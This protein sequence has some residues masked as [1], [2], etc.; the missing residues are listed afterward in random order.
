MKLLHVTNAYPPAPA[1]GG[2]ASAMRA[3]CQALSENT[4]ISINMTVAL[5]SSVQKEIDQAMRIAENDG[6]KLLLVDCWQIRRRGSTIGLIFPTLRG[7]KQLLRVV[8]SSDCVHIHGFRNSF[9]NFAGLLGVYFDKR[10]IVQPHGSAQIIG[11]SKIPKY[12]FDF[13][14]GRFLLRKSNY[15]L[16]LS[17]EEDTQIR[18]IDG[19]AEIV[20]I[21]NAVPPALAVGHN[22]TDSRSS[23][24]INLL[25]VGRL[26][27]KKGID[28]LVREIVGSDIGNRSLKLRIVGPD[29]GVE[30]EVRRLSNGDARIEF[31]GPLSGD[32]LVQEYRRADLLVVPSVTDT[33]PMVILEAAANRLPIAMTPSVEVSK[34]LEGLVAVLDPENLLPGIFSALEKPVLTRLKT[35]TREISMLYSL[36]SLS[37]KLCKIY[38]ISPTMCD[39]R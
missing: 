27:W 1:A 13:L 30:K 35:S 31:L 39:D 17:E 24:D 38:G 8:K 5:V 37:N 20:R 11:A 23:I 2:V 19:N 22:V 3:Q 32:S 36:G 29:D 6:V 14:F 18:E 21:W 16:S 12:V 25:F 9:S 33:F 7:L 15:V 26:N 34:S 4:D 10:V 28:L